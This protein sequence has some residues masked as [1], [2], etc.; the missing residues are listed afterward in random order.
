MNNKFL[1]LFLSLLTTFNASASYSYSTH[2]VKSI[3]IEQ[4][5]QQQLAPALALAVAKVE[6]DFNVK[7]ISE[8][9]ARGVMQIMPQTAEKVF[10]VH[11]DRL[12]DVETN[13]HL[14]VKFLQQLI[15]RYEQRLDLALSHYNGGSAVKG[16]NGSYKVIPSTQAYV[17]KVLSYYR[18]FDIK[19][20]YSPYHQASLNQGQG[21]NYL[22]GEPAKAAPSL[23][24]TSSSD[25]AKPANKSTVSTTAQT[26]ARTYSA[27]I[28]IKGPHIKPVEK[29]LVSFYQPNYQGKN[30]NERNYHQADYR[31]SNQQ[32]S[33]SQPNKPQPVYQPRRALAEPQ[34][35]D[36]YTVAQPLPQVKVN[37]LNDSDNKKVASYML[38]DRQAKVRQWESIFK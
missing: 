4:A 15:T 21:Y 28:M 22:I 3:I 25:R 26:S 35:L 9:G 38:D 12:F 31:A 11:R 36:T 24:K 1:I 10:G 16:K 17:D 13:I 20:S 32:A 7:A 33:Y 27:G 37:R 29:Q 30:V 34:W 18:Q 2:D 14:G 5:Q 23:V 6:S 19:E 8:A